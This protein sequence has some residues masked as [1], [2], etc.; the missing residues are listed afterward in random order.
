MSPIDPSDPP[1]QTQTQTQA[2]TQTPAPASSTAPPRTVRVIW[3]LAGGAL[4]LF[5]IGQ[6][7]LALVNLLAFHRVTEP[8]TTTDI[9]DI[10]T[11]RISGD[12]GSVRVAGAESG[13]TAVSGEVRLQGD[14]WSPGHEERIDGRTLVLDS[15]CPVFGTLACAADYRLTVPPEVSLE[16]VM[17]GDSDI[18]GVDGALTVDAGGGGIVVQGGDGPLRLHSSGGAISVVDGTG[19]VT[20][21]SAG[22]GITLVDSVAGKVQLDSSGGSISVS[23]SD[24]PRDVIA[25]SSGGSVIVRVPRDPGGYAVEAEATGGA[26]T[27]EV[28]TDPVA[29]RTILARSG[30]RDVAVVYREDSAGTG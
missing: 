29:E 3:L 8:L 10:D 12:S 19:P 4:A 28:R 26:S 21:Q 22:G 30:G 15:W 7:S 13:S 9:G 5:A 20:A 25:R 6:T 16:I 18:A 24:P 11:I 23:F 1:A 14:L 2:Q 27:V 17:S